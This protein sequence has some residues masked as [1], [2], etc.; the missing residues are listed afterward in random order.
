MRLVS[1][2]FFFFREPKKKKK[3]NEFFTKKT[4]ETPPP[5]PHNRERENSGKYLFDFSSSCTQHKNFANGRHATRGAPRVVV[6]LAASF[7]VEE[8]GFL[9]FRWV[10]LR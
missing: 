4:G 8:G 2:H 3:K 7:S 5:P 9:L 6:F 1:D 10:L